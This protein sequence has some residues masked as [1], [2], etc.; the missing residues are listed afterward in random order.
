MYKELLSKIKPIVES[1]NLNPYFTCA[2]GI[3][4]AS[5]KGF[6]PDGYP[7]I[8]F[9]KHVMLRY[10]RKDNSSTK[11][12]PRI[13]AISTSNYNA[14]EIAMSVDP[15]KAMLSTSYGLFQIMGFN[16]KV[17]G[18]ESV[19]DFVHAMKL[20]EDEHIKAFCKFIQNNSLVSIVNNLNFAKFAYRYNGPMYSKNSYD[21][22]LKKAYDSVKSLGV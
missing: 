2:V 14:Y 8:R 5:G 18:Y 16:H 19:G 11:F 7:K 10:M 15:H 20:S 12:I 1:F 4:E 3:V 9:E 17:A 22:K 13:E 6:R 21:I